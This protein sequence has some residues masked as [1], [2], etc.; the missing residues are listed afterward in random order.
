MQ[1]KLDKGYIIRILRETGSSKDFSQQLSDIEKKTTA[2][3]PTQ[4]QT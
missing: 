3:S 2:F 1:M 4:T